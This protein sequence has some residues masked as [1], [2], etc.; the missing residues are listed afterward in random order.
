MLVQGMV[1]GDEVM[2]MTE[3]GR[4]QGWGGAWSGLRRSMGRAG[5]GHGQV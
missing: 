3:E 4:G 2:V 5:E 1:S